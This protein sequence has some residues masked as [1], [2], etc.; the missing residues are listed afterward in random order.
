MSLQG[1]IENGVVVLDEPVSLP[2]GTAVRIE[3]V[4]PP[5]EKLESSG[6]VVADSQQSYTVSQ[7]AHAWKAVA[8]PILEEDAR[9]SVDPDD[10][11]YAERTGEESWRCLN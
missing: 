4:I 1:H 6:P 5:K 10:Y 9:L 3:P 2:N 7:M 8:K 11:P